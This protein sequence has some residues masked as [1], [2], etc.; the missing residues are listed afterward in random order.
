MKRAIFGGSFNPIHNDH[1]RLALAFADAFG[2]DRVTIIPTFMTPLKDNS[3]IVDGAHRLA[4]C[5]LAAQVDER[6]EVSDVELRR[7][8]MSYTSDTLAHFV[9][10]GDELYLIVG[11][12]MYVTLDRWHEY[13]YLF[14]HATI[15]VAPR[16]ELDY[17]S[18]SEKYREYQAENCH[19]LFLH[20][21]VGPLSSTAVREAAR[22]GESLGG[23]VDSRVEAYIREHGLY[24]DRMIG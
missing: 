22:R 1:I 13:R 12:D 5:R 16:D 24:Q 21:G 18:L 3:A 6:L 2:L 8:G 15:L 17:N 10:K 14:D 9:D 19:T 23:M 20:S 4:M 7:G 11:A